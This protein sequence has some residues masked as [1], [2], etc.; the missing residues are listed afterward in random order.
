MI[1]RR[2]IQL[3]YF[4][5]LYALIYI[6]NGI[7][8]PFISIYLKGIGLNGATIGS[9]M[10][11]GPFVA[12]IAQP[13]WGMAGDRAKSKNSVLKALLAGSA[14][15]V[16]LY[17]LSTNIYFLFTIIMI[18]TFFQTSV[19]PISDTI[20]LEHI[21]SAGGN[22]GHIRLSGTIGYAIAAVVTG[23]FVKENVTNMFVLYF[24]VLAATFL[25]VFKLP[26]VKG[27]QS[28]GNKLSMW[29]L[30]QNREL[31]LLMSLNGVVQITL[32]FYYSFFSIYCKEMGGDDILIGW[33]MFVSAISEIPFLLF[34]DKILKKL[35]VKGTLLI[36]AGGTGVRWLL[37]SLVTNPYM[38]LPLSLMHSM[39]F[40]I[41]TFSMATYIN[42]SVPKELRASGQTMNSLIGLGLARIIGSMGGGF[43]SDLVGI[44][45]VFQYVAILDFIAAAAFGAIFLKYALKLSR[46]QI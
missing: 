36:S 7:Y 43:L 45:Q 30:F 29:K 3:Y 20:T 11:L 46:R 6:G 27:H 4:F 1:R 22:F 40:A 41:L 26:P 28:E 24:L 18:Y 21:D 44:R 8:G 2:N 33:A 14:V 34:A 13:V 12:V 15:A 5:V 16:A 31:V 23:F 42:K 37:T 10:A 19:T 17:P 25:V 9:L 38:F 32:G 39:G 35:G